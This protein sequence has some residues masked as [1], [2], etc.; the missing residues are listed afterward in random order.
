M[1]WR[2]IAFEKWHPTEIIGFGRYAVHN[3]ETGHVRLFENRADAE[4]WTAFFNSAIFDLK[5]IDFD[6]IP[7][8]Y[9]RRREL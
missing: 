3:A 8:R 9:E 7:E 6:R 1:S 4:K 2:N 5:P